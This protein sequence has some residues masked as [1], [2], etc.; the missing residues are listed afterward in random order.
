MTR[1]KHEADGHVTFKVD[2]DGKIKSV[3][4]VLDQN[5]YSVA[6]RA[7]EARNP[8]ILNGDLERVRQRWRVTN[9]TVRELTSDDG[10][11]DEAD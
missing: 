11:E 7:H 2:M 4:S 5:N 6:I 8:V 9:A 3:G 1:D 10:D